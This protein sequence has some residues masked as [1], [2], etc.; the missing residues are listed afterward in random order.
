MV[1]R[2]QTLDSHVA[3]RGRAEWLV[4]THCCDSFLRHSVRHTVPGRLAEHSECNGIGLLVYGLGCA[5]KLQ[6]HIVFHY[7]IT[8][9][10][11]LM[12]AMAL[13]SILAQTLAVLTQRC[14]CLRQSRSMPCSTAGLREIPA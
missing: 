11:R 10:E 5:W 3:S 13:T 7:S 2:V 8:V 4:G 14:Q 12:S 1:G 9:P 6:L